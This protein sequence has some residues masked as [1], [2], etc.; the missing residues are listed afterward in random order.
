VHAHQELPDYTV[1]FG[2]NQTRKEK[3][4]LDTYRLATHQ[5]QLGVLKRLVPSNL[6][7][8]QQTEG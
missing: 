6:A 3:P 5:K 2:D 7:K 1:V 4:G 8:W